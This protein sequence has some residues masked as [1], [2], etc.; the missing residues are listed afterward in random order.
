MGTSRRLIARLFAIGAI[1]LMA[2]LLQWSETSRQLIVAAEHIANDKLRQLLAV[3]QPETR[4]LV[5]DID[6]ASLASIGPWPWPRYRVADLVETLLGVYGAKAVGLDI[7]FP[8]PSA[9]EHSGDLRLAALG[10]QGPVI[11][12]Q[13]FD[14]THREQSLRTGVPVLAS[15]PIAMV[16]PGEPMS[17]TGFVANHA[18]L[19]RARC[20][21]NIGIRPDE[22]GRIRRV[23]LQVAWQGQISQLLPLAML[24]CNA[25]E[26]AASSFSQ[27]AAKSIAFSADSWEI[28][29]VRQET[30]YTVVSASDIL[31]GAA[32]SDLVRGRWVLVGSSALGLN[33]RAAT[34]LS[35]STAGVMVHAAVLTSLLDLQEAQIPVWQVDGR[36]LA[37]LWIVITL[38][39]LGWSMNRFRAW[40]VLPAIFT[41]GLAWLALSF[42]WLQHQLQFSIISPLLGYALVVILVPLE[43]WLLQREQGH[44]LRSFATYV[45]PTVLQQMLEK[46]I[47][48]PL[49]PKY[50]NITVVS[51]DMQNYT[52]L[53][54]QGSL[55]DTADL[56][57]GFLQCLTE[58][59]LHQGGTL[60]KYTGDGLVAFWGA[61][62]P[63]P[64]HAAFAIE[65]GRQMVLRVRQWNEERVS[66]G[67]PPARV[68]IGIETGPALVGD[69]GTRFRSTY[70]AVGDCINLASKLQAAARNLSTDLI[71]GPLAAQ[72]GVA[73]GDLIPIVEGHLLPGKTQP[74]TLW[75][76][77]G[78]PSS[79]QVAS[80]LDLPAIPPPS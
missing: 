30:A 29:Y 9:D 12:A 53:T 77:R 60:D 45:A 16:L 23:P 76:I 39:L 63:D 42:W 37:T 32:P 72:A 40:V 70:T 1:A 61:P 50:A 65:A 19:S 51:A 57:C 7:I 79:V 38:P 62:L 33:D 11:F 34:P 71:I 5:V 46:G 4:I 15:Q 80:S 47:Q 67:L 35:A 69:L 27:A 24:N 2:I 55:Q 21:G 64:D 66:H 68:R 59:V 73:R 25:S 41:L 58:P 14:F 8:S 48:N 44:I 26:P 3:D 20:V 54:G 22:D 74:V 56:T 78:L 13:A 52:G 43:W 49:V 31:S 75:T 18:G 36:W 17:A 28:P 6:E 10:E